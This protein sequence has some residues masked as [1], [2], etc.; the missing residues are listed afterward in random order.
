M[1]MN[2]VR[3]LIIGITMPSVSKLREAT[4]ASVPL[5]TWGMGMC[6]KCSKQL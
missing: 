1:W 3:T 4:G 6:V 5:A 2:V